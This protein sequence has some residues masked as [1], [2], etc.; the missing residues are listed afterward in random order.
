MDVSEPANAETDKDK[1]IPHRLRPQPFRS[2]L[3]TTKD[4]KEKMIA[5]K[6]WSENRG[7]LQAGRR[8]PC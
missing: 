5:L 4:F 3:K 8:G 6:I 7:A 1:P 2:T